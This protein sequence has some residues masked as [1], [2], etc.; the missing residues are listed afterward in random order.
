MGAG[1]TSRIATAT[2]TIML[3][4]SLCS[5]ASPVEQLVEAQ[6]G[7]E[8]ETDGDRTTIETEDGKV[9]VGTGTELP[10]DFPADLPT[11][12]ATLTAAL[13]GGGG[14]T[15]NYENVGRDEV[16][17]LENHFRAAGYEEVTRMDMSGVIQSGYQGEQ[18]VVTFVWDGSGDSKALIYGITPR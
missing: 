4:I 2:A 15:L 3:T 9:E 7:T 13:S 10:T 14:W 1:T 6:T 8:I 18:W 12:D 16:E 17:Q 11:P 5:C